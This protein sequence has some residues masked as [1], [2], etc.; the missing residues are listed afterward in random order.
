MLYYFE[1]KISFKDTALHTPIFCISIENVFIMLVLMIYNSKA[2][3]FL[4]DSV[5][6]ENHRKNNYQATGRWSFKRNRHKNISQR[7]IISYPIPKPGEIVKPYLKKSRLAIMLI[8]AEGTMRR[9]S[10]SRNRCNWCT[11]QICEKGLPSYS[12]HM[13]FD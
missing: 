6:V 7:E 1:N 5:Q 13:F 10:Q 4:R 9:A 3:Q 11:R 12:Y 2:V 8:K